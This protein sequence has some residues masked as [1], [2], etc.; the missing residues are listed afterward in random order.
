[1]SKDVTNKKLV[2]SYLNEHALEKI[3]NSVINQ[4]V[5]ERPQDPFVM[6]AA[7]L[8]EHSSAKIG[9]L[10]ICGR[11]VLD[12]SG[13]PTVE[14]TVTTQ[15][16]EFTAS[17]PSSSGTGSS[18]TGSVAA[19]HLRDGDATRYNGLGVGQA[20]KNINELIAPVLVGM[21]PQD[22]NKIDAALVDIDGTGNMSKIGANAAL[23]VSIACARA[24]AMEKGVGLFRHLADLAEMRDVCLPVP[25]ISLLAGG[26][27]CGNKLTFRDFSIMP[28]GAASLKEAVRCGAE[29]STKLK[30][31][32]K[33]Q[34]GWSAADTCS[35]EGSM[36]PD[37]DSSETAI[38]LIVAAILAAGYTTEDV[39]LCLCVDANHFVVKPPSIGD[40]AAAAEAAIAAEA[41][42]A[43]SGEKEGD[44]DDDE[45]GGEEGSKSR[46]MPVKDY[47]L[48]PHLDGED[49]DA[50][51]VNG[52]A[53]REEYRALCEKYPDM[54]VSLEDPFDRTD[55]TSFKRLTEEM[56]EN[57][58][59]V[60]KCNL[61][62]CS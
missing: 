44:D 56:G 9:I 16:G 41:A 58:Q 11:E 62:C 42:V 17:A 28:I 38:D 3:L 35:L 33:E 27:Q 7:L 26:D 36:C 23:A 57:I 49:K 59:I 1:M 45:G 6:M 39:K 10:S 14:V 19:V 22:Q 29:I 51:I 5:K 30:E 8:K 12:S 48:T 13:T 21:V 15:Q 55:T 32:I 54:I 31:A 24:G 37:I 46:D 61:Y 18:D 2:E 34:F 20:V 53:L 25:T 4:C 60:G 43:E 40:D 47:N 50:K 52:D